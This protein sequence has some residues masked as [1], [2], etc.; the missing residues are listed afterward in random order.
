MANIVR[1][2]FP[3]IMPG[4]HFGIILMTRKASASSIGCADFCTFGEAIDPSALMMKLTTT[5]PSIFC[6]RAKGG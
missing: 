2:G 5:L 3:F 1:Q 6:C 4:F